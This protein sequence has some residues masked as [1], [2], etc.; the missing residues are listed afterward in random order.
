MLWTG[1]PDARVMARRVLRVR[2]LAAYFAA[3]GAAAFTLA[4]A[5]GDGLTAALR[6]GLGI[7]PAAALALAL[8]GGF[9]A[10]VARTTT[11]AI[12]DR[13]VVMRFGIAIPVTLNLPFAAISAADMKARSDGTGEIALA[14]TDPRRVLYATLWPHARPRRLSRPQPALR[15]LADVATP[16]R[17]LAEAL[18]RANGRPALRVVAAAPA[19]VGA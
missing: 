6:D 2:V 9:A 10:L 19:A 1:R 18:R 12:T 3:F 17:I 7:V 11:Y 4:A 5:R 15:G 8:I 13:R 14:L 16:A